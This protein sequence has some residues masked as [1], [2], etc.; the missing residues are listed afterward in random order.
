MPEPLAPAGPAGRIRLVI[1]DD[2]QVLRRALAEML[3]G[4][5]V[6]VVG[7]A[8]SG[9]HAVELAAELHPDVMVIDFRMADMDGIQA[10]SE[11]RVVWP[12]TEVV[13]LTAYDEQALSRDAE[14]AGIRTFLVKGC[15]PRLI[16]EAVVRAGRGSVRRRLD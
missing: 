2:D 9:R 6:E 11:V 14:R 1:V 3:D 10:A 12:E 15:P 16:H 7:V 5:D 4:D 13:M 8:G